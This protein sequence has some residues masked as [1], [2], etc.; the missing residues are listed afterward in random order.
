MYQPTNP[1]NPSDP[2][3]AWAMREHLELSR[4][5]SG[6]QDYVILAVL[7][8]EPARPREGMFVLADGTDWNPGAGAGR[9]LFLGGAWVN[10]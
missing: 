1:P 10:Y 5:L 9:Y 4:Y 2:A 8:K 3:Q 7:H 6:P